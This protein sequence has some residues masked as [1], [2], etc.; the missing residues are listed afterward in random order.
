M[1]T[2]VRQA[3][4]LQHRHLKQN[5]GVMMIKFSAM[6][7]TERRRVEGAPTSSDNRKHEAK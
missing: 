1:G 2:T 6:M 3:K 5:G 4:G 7:G